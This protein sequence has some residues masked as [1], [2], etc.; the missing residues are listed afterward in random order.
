MKEDTPNISL[1]LLEYLHKTYPNVLPRHE[2]S[3]FEM[4]VLL[5]QNALIEHLYSIYNKK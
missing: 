5:G 3:S 4:G 1:E 2:I